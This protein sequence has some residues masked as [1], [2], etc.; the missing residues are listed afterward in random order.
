MVSD[1]VRM[2]IYRMWFTCELHVMNRLHVNGMRSTCE[3]IISLE[4]WRV[5]L[6][7]EV[8]VIYMRLACE[9]REFRMRKYIEYQKIKIRYR[10]TCENVIYYM[11]IACKLHA[12]CMR[13]LTFHMRY[14]HMRIAYILHVIYWVFHM[15]L[16][17][18]F[19]FKAG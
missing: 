13:K 9:N 4:N 5:F 2:G 14:A 16:C 7:C 12:N 8:H 15:W 1:A 18:N 17:R 3:F 10:C 6:A 19:T 11:C